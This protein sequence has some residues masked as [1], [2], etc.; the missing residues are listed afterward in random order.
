MESKLSRISVAARVR[1]ILNS[2]I[3]NGLVSTLLDVEKPSSS[4]M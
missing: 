1:P 3:K 4:I 2:E